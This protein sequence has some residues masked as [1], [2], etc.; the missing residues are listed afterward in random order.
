MVD[1]IAVAFLVVALAAVLLIAYRQEDIRRF[2]RRRQ[3][4]EA[5]PTPEGGRHAPGMPVAPRFVRNVLIGLVTLLMAVVISVNAV[6]IVPAGHRGVMIT[7]GGKVEQVNYPEG[8]TFKMPFVQSVV[9]IPVMI[10]KAEVK[11]STASKDLQEITTHLAVHYRIQETSAWRVYQTMREDYLHLLVEPVIMEELK[12]TTAEWTAEELITDRPLVV[13]RLTERL[14]ERL[15]SFG[16]D[17]LTVNIIDF[18][19]S[20]EFWAAI[21]RKVVAQQDALTEKNKVEIARYKQMQNIINAEGQ[22]NVTVIT[23]N[24]EAMKKILEANGTSTS[25][26]LITE[27][28]TPEYATYLWIT[29]WDG[30]LPMFMGG[31]GANILI[32]LTELMNQTRAGS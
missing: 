11:E 12:A 16:I 22:Y 8:M 13:L 27:Q 6:A 31:E 28:L 19:F 1:V 23:A 15:Q 2:A 30:K 17:V 14:D 20:K 18:Q 9:S 26:R 25:I 24:A 4:F 21:E 10:Q 32:D 7:W 5:E 29:Q 3:G